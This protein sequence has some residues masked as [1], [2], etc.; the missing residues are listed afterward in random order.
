MRSY[1]RNNFNLHSRFADGTMIP[2]TPRWFLNANNVLH[3]L[4]EDYDCLTITL[5]ED[6]NAGA[7]ADRICNEEHVYICEKDGL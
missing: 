7:W 3:P 1:F 2:W 5:T 6:R 4:G